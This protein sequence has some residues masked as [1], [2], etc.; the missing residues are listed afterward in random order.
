[1]TTE[2]IV[3]ATWDDGANVRD[4]YEIIQAGSAAAAIAALLAQLPDADPRTLVVRVR[5]SPRRK[6]R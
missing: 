1:M 5:A 3:T 4:A 6:T 2:F